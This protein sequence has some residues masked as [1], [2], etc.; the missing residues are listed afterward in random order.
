MNADALLEGVREATATELSRL[1]SSKA[2]Y[3]DTGGDLD[4]E[5]VFRAAETAER[6][7]AETFEAWAD[8]EANETAAAAYRETAAEEREHAERVREELDGDAAGEAAGASDEEGVPALA[9]HL[10]GLDDTVARAG[11]FLGRVLVADESKSQYVGYFVG[12][13]D[14]QSAAVFRD[15]RGDLEGQ[16]ERALDLLD[17]V[18]ETEADWERAEAAAVEAVEAAYE[19]HVEALESLGVDPKPVC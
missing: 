7:A 10:R 2:L 6:A 18:C 14:P 3:A 4:A 12:D 11:G 19:A 1:G 9:A 5:T 8:A 17:A 13:A 15:L 16:R